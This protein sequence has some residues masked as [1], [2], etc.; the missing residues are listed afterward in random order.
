MYPELSPGTA[1]SRFLST[2]SGG[3]L[4]KTSMFPLANDGGRQCPPTSPR[5]LWTAQSRTPR[6]AMSPRLVPMFNPSPD[7]GDIQG[8]I[9]NRAGRECPHRRMSNVRHCAAAG[10][11]RG[12]KP[13]GRINS[14]CGRPPSS[15]ASPTAQRF[16]N[17][18]LTLFTT[19]GITGE[20]P[21]RKVGGQDVNGPCPGGLGKDRG[22][23][24]HPTRRSAAPAPSRLSSSWSR[25][26]FAG[27]SSRRGRWRTCDRV[28]P[29]RRPRVEPRREIPS[30]DRRADARSQR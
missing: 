7:R 23:T 5:N 9:D 6:G 30:G 8:D 22:R 29:G 27:V 1:F 24:Y 13:A 2:D 16:F 11:G 19:S 17:S 25:A 21:P 15:L 3:D 18:S 26:R 4:D 12:R 14:P 20:G 10:R 28:G